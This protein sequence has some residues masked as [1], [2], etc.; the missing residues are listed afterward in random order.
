MR[1]KTPFHLTVPGLAA[2]IAAVTLTV[3][4]ASAADPVADACATVE[5]VFARGSGQ[6]PGDPEANNFQLKIK[7]RL[8]PT[9]TIHQY[10]LGD[11]GIDGYSYPAVPVGMDKGLESLWNTVGAGIT[12]GGGSTY[13]DSVTEGVD[14]LNAYLGKRAAACPDALFVLGGCSQGAQVV[15]EAG[16]QRLGAS[17]H[18]Q[19]P[20]LTAI[21][22]LR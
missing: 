13:G 5:T 19:V 16:R 18:R 1:S 17:S 6:D 11:G 8:T 7:E 10:E 4:P 15:G 21:P 14:E 2:A 22:Q 3:P 12:G 20:R 9:A